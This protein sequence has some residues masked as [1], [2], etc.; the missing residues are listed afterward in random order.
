VS[1]GLDEDI[2][3]ACGFTSPEDAA[4]FEA[5]L[6]A[7]FPEEAKRYDLAVARML[8]RMRRA[9]RSNTQ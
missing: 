3:A 1:D 2:Y 7:E 5:E 9:D 4:R 6:N 8:R